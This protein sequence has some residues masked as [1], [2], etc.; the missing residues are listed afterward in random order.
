MKMPRATPLLV[1]LALA[2]CSTTPQWDQRFGDSVR[3][4]LADQLIDPEASSRKAPAE[5]LDGRAVAGALRGYADHR[6]FAVREPRPVPRP[7]VDYK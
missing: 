1:L 7:V 5:T 2:G 3:Q 4:A 6:D